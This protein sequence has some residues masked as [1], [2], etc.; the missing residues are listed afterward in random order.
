M[1]HPND[2][3]WMNRALQLAERGLYTTHPNPRVGCVLVVDAKVVGE[4]WHERAGGPHAE[5]V[6]LR[7]AG[8]LAQ[9]ATAYV[10][11]E[12]CAHTG[13]TGPC[14]RALIE[15]GVRR[16]VA[17]HQDP[18]PDVAGRGFAILQEAGI[19]VSVGVLEAQARALN[20]GF[21]RRMQEGLPWV[22]LKTASSL[23]G[24]TAMANGQSK[25]ITA[26][27][28]RSDVQ[29]W[30]ARS[31]AILTGVGTILADDPELTLRPELWSECSAPERLQPWRV[32]MDTHLRTP[33]QA[34]LFRTEP[35]RVMILH[36]A[37]PW[38]HQPGDY[39]EGVVLHGFAETALDP[40]DVLRWLAAHSI[41]EILLE[42]GA[43]LAG[44]FMRAG[45]VNEWVMYQ[46]LTLLGS[47]ARPLLE[48][49]MQDMS[50]QRRMSLLDVRQVGDDLRMILRP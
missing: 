8:D 12:P 43:T 40:W 1:T 34:R 33:V 14:A 11:L 18:N 32:V 25:W 19:E 9:G 44:S 17:A 21:L 2:R 6:A 4:G 49:S 39:P 27:A 41:Q 16:V 22:R 48:W 42:A 5:V 36:G 45:L 24:R 20:P 23:D 28:A 13:R 7:A 3:V 38:E 35:E 10:T 47:T 46:A 31:D 15:A 50:E 30:R 29:R 37:G 26:A